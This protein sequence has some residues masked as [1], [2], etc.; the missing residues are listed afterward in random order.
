MPMRRS[1]FAISFALQIAIVAFIAFTLAASA[2]KTPTPIKIVA[3]LSDAPRKLY[4]AEIDLPVNTGDATAGDATF[5]TPQWIPGTHRPLGPADAIT[6]VVFTANGKTLPW[7]RDEV[8]LY[9]F[10]VT[11]PAGVTTVHAHLDSIV[12][13]RVSQKL[14]AFEWEY[15]LLYP[16]GIPVKEIPIEPSVKVPDGWGIGT[17]L[18]PVKATAYPVPAPGSTT[19]FAE[20]TVEQ[21]ED[22]PVLT[23]QYFHEY[24]LA[25]EISPKH[26]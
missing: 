20:T 1:G 22:S 18:T 25:P 2:Q 15:L 10:H 17:A 23:G 3:D 14:A 24:A 26:F 19:E 16:A 11:I 7:R 21:L 12:T 8:K 6:G 5:I 4:H 9:E 13:T